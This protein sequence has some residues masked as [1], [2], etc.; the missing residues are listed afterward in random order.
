MIRRPPRPTRTDTLFPYATLFRSKIVFANPYAVRMFGAK[1][2]DD[3]VGRETMSL[4]HP[5]D[6]PRARQRTQM[7]M[8]G[9]ASVPLAELRMVRLDGDRMSTR[10]N[11]SH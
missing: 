6:L 3:V 7:I 10:L 2:P 8:D 5:D 4:L 1:S 11:S 9:A